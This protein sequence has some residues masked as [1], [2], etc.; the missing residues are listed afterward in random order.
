VVKSSNPGEG[1]DLPSRWRLD[2]AGD[3]RVGAERHVRP[4]VVV[5]LHVLADGAEEVTLTE[6]D[7]VIEQLA[8]KGPDETLGVAVRQGDRAAIFIW[9]IPRLSTRALKTAP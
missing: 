6:D 2:G 7:E 4:V 9:R 1:D 5:V 3:R 8:S